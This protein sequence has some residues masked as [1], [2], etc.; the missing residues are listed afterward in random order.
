MFLPNAAD[1]K[2]LHKNLIISRCSFNLGSVRVSLSKN[3]CPFERAEHMMLFLQHKAKC[4]HKNVIRRRLHHMRDPLRCGGSSNAAKR[5]CPS[6]SS[7]AFTQVDIWHMV[8]ISF[9]LANPECNTL[10]LFKYHLRLTFCV[11]GRVSVRKWGQDCSRP[12]RLDCIKG[13]TQLVK[14]LPAD[15]ILVYIILGLLRNWTA[16]CRRCR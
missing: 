15:R 4:Q 7:S 12:Y 9:V 5:F 16:T 8:V 6:V 14:Q 10:E 1:Q 3:D 11:R 13:R 2:V